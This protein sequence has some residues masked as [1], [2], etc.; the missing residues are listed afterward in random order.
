MEFDLPYFAI[1]FDSLVGSAG[2]L[3]S[4]M[5]TSEIQGKGFPTI[6]MSPISIDDRTSGTLHRSPSLSLVLKTISLKGILFS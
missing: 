3:T 2:I 1:L 4:E 5:I 6:Q